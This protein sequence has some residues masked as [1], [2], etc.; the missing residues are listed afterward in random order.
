MNGRSWMVVCAAAASVVAG[1]MG[2][3]GA[4]AAQPAAKVAL[5]TAQGK[6]TLNG[7]AVVLAHAAAIEAP[8]SWDKT[9]RAYVVLL[10]AKPL[11]AAWFEGVRNPDP[12][13]LMEKIDMGLLVEF[14]PDQKTF[15]KFRHP[16]LDPFVLQPVFTDK[17]PDVAGPDRVEGTVANSDAPA[18]EE[19]FIRNK[20]K[21]GFNF[22][23]NAR[24]M[25]RF[26]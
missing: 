9:K 8:Y 26:P 2:A 18:E 10:T 3:A 1:T 25:K 14:G 12:M 4:R 21:M 23:F 7:Q 6:M 17:A 16:A 13:A 20:P 19:F 5:G 15:F 22:R 11:D 24:V